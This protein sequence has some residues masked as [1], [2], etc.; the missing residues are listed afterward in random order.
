MIPLDILLPLILLAI[1]IVP[2]VVLAG[3]GA[4]I[5]R[6]RGRPVE[7][8]AQ[9]DGGGRPACEDPARKHRRSAHDHTRAEPDDAPL[10]IPPVRARR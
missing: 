1:V 8:E 3:L 7:P 2:V 5:A 6:R 9:G 4:K 10:A